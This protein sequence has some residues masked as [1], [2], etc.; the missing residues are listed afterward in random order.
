MT[1][2]IKGILPVVHMPYHQ[3]QSIDHT[4]LR[5]QVDYLF[6]TGAH[7]LCLALVSDLLRLTTQ[8]RNTLPA[9]L[10]EWAAGRGPVII[11]VGAESAIQA[12]AYARA[13][14]DAGAAALMAIPP[15]TQA[16][17]ESELRAYFEAIL[18]AVD[19]PLMVQDASSYVGTPMTLQ[20]Q[21]SLFDDHGDRI[22][23]KPEATPLGPCLSG[24]RDLTGGQAALFEGS[25]GVLLID[26]FR[27]GIAGSIPGVELLHGVVPLW[28]ALQRRDDA[29]AYALHAPISA[30]AM[31][32][33]QGGLDGFIGIERHIMY[34]RGIFENTVNRLPFSFS[35]DAETGAEIDRI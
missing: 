9:L 31:L 32:Q 28:N 11:N 26:S 3:D 1:T 12:C 25:G 7:G 8:E 18:D 22:L 2:E 23:F 20:F 33:L 34:R 35:L 17:P 27:R 16:V 19:V 5:K 6:E 15:L 10:V 13:A 30:I 21:A 24:L 4:T 29:M 14:A